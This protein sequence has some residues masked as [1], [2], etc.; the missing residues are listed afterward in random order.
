M[1]GPGAVTYG[2]KSFPNQRGQAEGKQKDEQIIDSIIKDINNLKAEKKTFK[3]VSVSQF[4]E[5]NG[6][7]DCI[8]EKFKDKLKPTQLRKVFHSLKAVQRKVEKEDPNHLFNRETVAL[9]LPEL[10]YAVGRELIPEKFYKLFKTCFDAQ[11]LQTNADFL[12][13]MDFLTAV[14]AFHKYRNQRR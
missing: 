7:A 13:F 9:L 12:R 3:D 2:G 6:W 14:L 4:A 11:L 10:A 5:E 8:A 1:N